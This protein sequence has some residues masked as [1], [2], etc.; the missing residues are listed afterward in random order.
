[1]GGG[2]A[3]PGSVHRGLDAGGD[4]RGRARGDSA[5][6]ADIGARRF[7]HAVEAVYNARMDPNLSTG[8]DLRA[9]VEASARHEAL[10]EALGD[11]VE[12]AGRRSSPSWR[13]R[14]AGSL[15][16][17]FDGCLLE[18]PYRSRACAVS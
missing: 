13:R 7:L 9:L 16:A 6:V 17:C 11:V 5:P 14:F 8:T 4:Y 1:V 18:L 3:P 12:R 15:R 2:D 10:L